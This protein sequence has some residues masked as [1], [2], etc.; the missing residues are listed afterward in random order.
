MTD[1]LLME[2]ALKQYL[3]CQ[4]SIRSHSMSFS[5]QNSLLHHPYSATDPLSQYTP[6]VLVLFPR[7]L[8]L[9]F[10]LRLARCF[11]IFSSSLNSTPRLPP[12]HSHYPEALR[13]FLMDPP[14]PPPPLQTLPIS[15]FS[16]PIFNHQLSPL[17]SCLPTQTSRSTG[18]INPV[19]LPTIS[20]QPRGAQLANLAR[21]FL[22]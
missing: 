12:L 15:T 21:L 22:K 14:P 7:S 2:I 5:P 11:L 8:V 17:L 20:P 16:L 9:L 4:I 6:P 1:K 3:I 19:L 18:L 10:R 13:C